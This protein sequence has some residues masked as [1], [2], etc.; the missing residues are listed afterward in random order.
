MRATSAMNARAG[1]TR[2]AGV[3]AVDVGQQHQRVGTDQVRDECGEPVVVAEADLVRGDRV[4]LVDDRDRHRARAA[5]R[6]CGRRCGSARADAGRRRSAAPARRAGRTGR[7]TR[8]SARRAAAARRSPRPAGWRGRAGEPAARA[9]RCPA[10]IAPEDTS[11]TCCR[12]R[13]R[14]ATASTM[15]SRRCRVEPTASVSDDDPTF[16]TRAPRAGDPVARP[17]MPRPSSSRHVVDVRAGG[18]VFAA[19]ARRRAGAGGGV[20]PLV[21]PRAGRA[22]SR[23]RRCRRRLEVERDAADRHGGARAAP[24]RASS[25]ST[26]RRLQPVGEIADRLVVARSRSAAPS[27][28]A[29]RHARCSRRGSRGR[30]RR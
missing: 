18:P 28:P 8:R 13:R 9:G 14:A 7:T 12:R 23:S 27:A 16:T 6:G 1:P 15:A 29:S 26:P 20:Q 17:V 10:A 30:D 19:A 2:L 3:E 21:V 25:S 24:W 4:V 22:G 5:V 11:T